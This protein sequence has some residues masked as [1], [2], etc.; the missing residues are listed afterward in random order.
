MMLFILHSGFNG[1]RIPPVTFVR[2]AKKFSTS[3]KGNASASIVH[4][5]IPNEYTSHLESYSSLLRICNKK[6]NYSLLSYTSGAVNK[7]VPTSVDLLV[8][9]SESVAT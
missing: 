6:D 9:S 5:V 8:I 2:R 4:I 1:G 7:G 3:V